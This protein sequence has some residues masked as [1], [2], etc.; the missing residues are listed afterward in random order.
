MVVASDDTERSSP[1][2]LKRSSTAHQHGLECKMNCCAEYLK[3]FELEL[4]RNLSPC[5]RHIRSTLSAQITEFISPARLYTVR[6]CRNRFNHLLLYHS[7]CSYSNHVQR[8]RSTF[9][10]ALKVLVVQEVSAAPN[11]YGINLEEYCGC[12][13]T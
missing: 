8:F 2:C 11:V 4:W 6:R 5:Q 13:G 12:I 10:T 7:T 3:S 1:P 9:K